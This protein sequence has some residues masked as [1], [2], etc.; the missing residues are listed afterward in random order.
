[1]AISNLTSIVIS[2]IGENRIKEIE[3]AKNGFNYKN[4]I[5]DIEKRLDN[6]GKIYIN[7]ATQALRDLFGSY[8]K[9]WEYEKI[10]KELGYNIK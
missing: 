7:P 6:D 8:V 1:M 3:T 5:R 2:V 4:K 10:E 9:D